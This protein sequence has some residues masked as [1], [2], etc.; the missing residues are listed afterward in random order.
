[1]Y[2]YHKETKHSYYSVRTNPNRMDWNL[3]PSTYK[4]YPNSFEKFTLDKAHPWHS[5]IYY[6]ASISTKKYYPSGTHRFLRVNP[7]AGALYPN[8]IYFQARGVDGFE[9][10][11]YH[12]EVQSNRAVLLYR[13]KEGEGIEPYMAYERAMEGLL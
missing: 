2:W 3:Q 1:M 4:N 11:L 5:I 13:L 7:S 12:Y 10:G 9:D 8:E 6:A